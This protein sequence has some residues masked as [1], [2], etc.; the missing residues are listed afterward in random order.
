M[1]K[2]QNLNQNPHA[3]CDRLSLYLREEWLKTT[4]SI[5]N[6]NNG[7]DLCQALSNVRRRR[8]VSGD[9]NVRKAMTPGDFTCTGNRTS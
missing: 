2:S 5:S 3:V 8:K 6:G 4:R 9:S 7:P 1:T